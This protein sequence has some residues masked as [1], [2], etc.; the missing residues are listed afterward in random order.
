MKEIGQMFIL[1]TGRQHDLE[2][3]AVI[4]EDHSEVSL[5]SC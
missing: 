4:V 1:N 2:D 3:D 5:G